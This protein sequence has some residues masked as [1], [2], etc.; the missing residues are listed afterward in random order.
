ML[1][2]SAPVITYY[3][4]GHSS[5]PEKPMNLDRVEL[6]QVT[7]DNWVAKTSNL[8]ADEFEFGPDLAG[9]ASAAIDLPLHW[10]HAVWLVSTWNTGA[11]VTTR[12]SEASI[13]VTQAQDVDNALS[14]A[15]RSQAVVG[16]TIGSGLDSL[17]Q[18]SSNAPHTAISPA[19]LDYSHEVKMFADSFDSGYT[20]SGSDLALE[21]DDATYTHDQL[22]SLTQ[23]FLTQHNIAPGGR[24][25]FADLPTQPGLLGA[26]IMRIGNSP[27]PATL[28]LC[29]GLTDS[30]IEHVASQ[31][32]AISI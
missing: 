19:A 21:T 22:A 10:L 24:V 28:V 3:S 2:N 4:V 16:V 29:D 13:I 14:L 1:L 9:E 18:N 23:D 15:H 26:L 20:P 25:L 5:E 27:A 12:R 30:Q 17:D 6:S 7:V 8:L 32:R 31:E 11:Y